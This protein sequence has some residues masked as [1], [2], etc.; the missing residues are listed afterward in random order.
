MS[1][2][3][4]NNEIQLKTKKPNKI[5]KFERTFYHVRATSLL[6][7]GEMG[8]LDLF[9]NTNRPAHVEFNLI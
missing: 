3:T 7:Y 2:H 4:L 6:K 8:S 1:W 9:D 5:R